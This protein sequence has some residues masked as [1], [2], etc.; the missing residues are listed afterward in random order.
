MNSKALEPVKEICS[1]ISRM[2]S[3]LKEVLPKGMHVD[4][5]ISTT[6]NAIQTH[7]SQEKLLQADRRTLFLAV[8]KCCADGLI[9]DGRE[10]ALTVRGG[11]V[12]YEPMAQGLVKRAENTGKISKIDSEVV[13]TSDKFHYRPGIDDQPLF[14]PDWKIAPSDRGEA[15]L[16][17]AVVTLKDG[18][19]IT[20]ILH[21]E[22]VMQIGNATPN[23]GQ[24]ATTSDHF[25][26]WWR[27]T[28]IRN[29]LKYTPKS[30]ALDNVIASSDE[31]FDGD[32]S[33]FDMT[34]IPVAPKQK[35]QTRAAAK[36]IDTDSTEIPEDAGP[37]ESDTDPI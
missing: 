30:S 19:K 22:R 13:Y 4:T 2:S 28:A 21:K 8:Q 7:P 12:V 34:D 5:F 26:E 33:D 18:S 29:V 16:V 23:K 37:D 14:E 31:A 32:F 10:A 36:I 9:L 27:K 17:Y 20:R 6:K 24:Y 25:T 3:S 15:I 1:V 11:K 35:G